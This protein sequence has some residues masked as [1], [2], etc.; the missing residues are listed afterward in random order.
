MRIF[1]GIFLALFIFTAT[2][3]GETPFTVTRHTDTTF[4]NQDFDNAMDDINQ[5]LRIDN[6]RCSDVPCSATFARSGNVGT[7]GT[8]GDGLDRITTQDELDDVFAINTHRVKVV[9]YLERCAGSNNPSYIGCGKCNAFGYILEE[10]VSGEVYVHEYGHNVIGCGHREDCEWNIMD[11]D[12]DGT[13]DAVNSSECSSFGGKAYTELCGNV[14]DG[15]GGPL[16]TSGG[17][18]WVTCTVTVP[19]GETLTINQGVEIQFKHD[20]KLTINGE[21]DAEGTTTD[22]ILM[23]SNS[24]ADGFPS[25]KIKRDMK[26]LNGGQIKLY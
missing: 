7:F 9:T 26:L 23:Y 13:N 8:T 16:T 18:Y 4:T 3:S 25:M 19:S 6:D 14:Y 21:L 17:P 2:V 20:N 11:D 1:S 22:Q 5:R 24:I 10:W 12:T 15:N